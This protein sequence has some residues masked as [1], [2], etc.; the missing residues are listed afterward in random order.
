MRSEQERLDILRSACL[1]C[2]MCKSIGGVVIDGCVSNVF[3]SGGVR[4][5]LAVVGQNPGRDEVA[6]GMPFVGAS[7]RFF[8]EALAEW[9]GLSRDQVYATNVVHCYTPGNRAPTLEEL[10]NCRPFL[11]EE[12][13]IVR[14]KVVLALGAFAFK[15]LTGMSGIMKHCG[16]VVHS[17]RYGVQVVG[18]L[19]PSPY[20]TS[21][22]EKREMFAQAMRRLREVLDA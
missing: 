12:I 5:A 8:D 16:D 15:M 11:E 1:E 7:G 3:S 4:C 14:P 10:D 9:V 13:E 18:C 21:D 22:P 2:R 6:A 19:H 20:N 17:I